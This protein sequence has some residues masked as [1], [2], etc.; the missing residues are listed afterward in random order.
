MI[1]GSAEIRAWYL[2]GSVYYLQTAGCRPFNSYFAFLHNLHFWYPLLR[3]N[4]KQDCR[5][6]KG[7]LRTTNYGLWTGYKIWTWVKN[8]DCGLNANCW[9]LTQYKIWTKVQN[10]DLP[11]MW[12]HS[13]MGMVFLHHKCHFLILCMCYHPKIWLFHISILLFLKSFISKIAKLW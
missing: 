8:A 6:R 4:C 9:L 10:A 13:K 7:V 2:I 11:A 3:P 12:P 5:L 1:D